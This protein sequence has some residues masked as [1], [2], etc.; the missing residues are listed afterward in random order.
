MLGEELIK[1]IQKKVEEA[2]IE[3]NAKAR[4]YVDV[5]SMARQLGFARIDTGV[6]PANI[7]AVMYLNLTGKFSVD[8]GSKKLIATNNSYDEFHQRFAIAHELGHY[9]CGH[10]PM[11]KNIKYIPER[12]SNT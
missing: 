9:F 5:E 7:I 1:K 12:I 11:P 6:L 8:I 3:A 4:G 10:L 2:K